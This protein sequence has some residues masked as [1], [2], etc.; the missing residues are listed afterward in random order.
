MSTT[1]N[2]P[3][4]RVH[5]RRTMQ[6]LEQDVVLKACQWGALVNFQFLKY[7]IPDKDLHLSWDGVEALYRALGWLLEHR[8]PPPNS[9]EHS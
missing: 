5:I 1:S 9:G 8:P 4:V 2:L 3:Q 7:R 6:T